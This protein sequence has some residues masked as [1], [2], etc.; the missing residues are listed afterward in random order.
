MGYSRVSIG[1]PVCGRASRLALV[2]LLSRW[3]RAPSAVGLGEKRGPSWGTPTPS[4]S[5]SRVAISRLLANPVGGTVQ[6]LVL[7]PQS[8]PLHLQA[9]VP[10]PV[11]P[12]SLLSSRQL[13]PTSTLYSS[14]LRPVPACL[15][16]LPTYHPPVACLQSHPH[17]HP[18]THTPHT[19]GYD[20]RTHAR[21]Q[22]LSQTLSL[23]RTHT[24][25][26]TQPPPSVPLRPPPRSR[27]PSDAHGCRR[28][29]ALH[30]S[31]F[32]GLCPT[33][34]ALLIG[35]SGLTQARPRVPPKAPSGFSHHWPQVPALSHALF[36]VSLLQRCCMRIARPS[37][38]R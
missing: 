8:K 21:T 4:T 5:K 25:T 11:K 13:P 14:L 23:L 31:R 7:L 37:K 17:P 29:H 26:R 27:W 12:S 9:A 19:S 34:F 36:P 16:Y 20:T 18:P 15:S 2:C 3:R 35:P 30:A 10:S 22:R 32:A 24:C 28:P 1:A 38:S 33:A 6:R